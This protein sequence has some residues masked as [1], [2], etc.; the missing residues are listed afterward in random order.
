M[1]TRKL[2]QIKAFAAQKHAGQK[3]GDKEYTEHLKEVSQVI[4]R[5]GYE[6]TPS[7]FELLLECAFLH[8]TL[9]D[10]STTKQELEEQFGKEVA[11]L[12]YL[13]SDEPGKSRKERKQKTYPK[14]ASSGTAIALKLADRIANVEHCIKTKSP[15][16]DM[17]RKE[18]KDFK[19][20]LENGKLQSM[21]AVLDTLMESK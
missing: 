3:Y 14:I 17:Y 1:D 9:E 11:E 2:D 12:V 7:D 20:Y 8:D 10:T 4:R 19:R 21:W 18:H 16:L 5:F 6:F 15:L 13:V